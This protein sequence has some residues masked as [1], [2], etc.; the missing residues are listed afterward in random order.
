[1]VWRQKSN[2]TALVPVDGYVPLD[3]GVP[4]APSVDWGGL[5]RSA[6][7]ADDPSAFIDGSVG[8]SGWYFAIGAFRSW[9]RGR[10]GIPSFVKE[11]GACD[12]ELW[13]R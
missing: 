5:E 7:Y 4:S 9:D 1:M 11:A 2:P 3:V 13:V 10:T 12:V 6:L 8:S